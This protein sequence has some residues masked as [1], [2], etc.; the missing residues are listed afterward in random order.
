M[1]IEVADLVVAIEITPGATGALADTFP[2]ILK[3]D[4]EVIAVDI[5][6]AIYVTKTL[7]KWRARASGLTA[8][9]IQLRP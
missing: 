3:Q 1:S 2:L 8:A 7:A 9:Q 6:I 5:I 4:V